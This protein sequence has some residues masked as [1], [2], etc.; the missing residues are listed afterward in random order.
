MILYSVTVSIDTDVHTEWLQWMK[1]VH[2]PEVMETGCFLDNKILKMLS[3][4]GEGGITYS[5]QYLSPDQ[6]TYDRYQRE[7]APALQQK[8]TK[9]YAGKFAAFRTLLEVVYHR[10]WEQA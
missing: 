4:E 2:I 7:F 3:H 6:E 8:H 9:R 1:E 5:I 10:Q